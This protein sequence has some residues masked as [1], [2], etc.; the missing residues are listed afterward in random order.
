MGKG[1]K[2][3][4][5]RPYR[6]FPSGEPLSS[7]GVQANLDTPVLGKQT[8]QPLTMIEIDLVRLDRAIHLLAQGGD[9]VSVQLGA[10]GLHVLTEWGRLGNVPP[11]Y[12]Q[13]ILDNSLLRGS[14]LSLD[15]DPLQVG[16]VLT[17]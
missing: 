9:L 14:V 3:E 13:I 16:V 7:N 6:G 4:K 15:T 1:N 8:S 17:R 12:E 11:H 2:K 10:A 5:G